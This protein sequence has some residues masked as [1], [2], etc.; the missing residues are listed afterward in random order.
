MQNS[1]FPVETSVPLHQDGVPSP[2]GHKR[3][4]TGEP[5]QQI[6]NSNHQI[7]NFIEPWSDTIYVD[8]S[9]STISNYIKE[10]QKISHFNI[11][12]RI[13]SINDEKTNNIII[14]FDARKF[15]QEHCKFIADLMSIIEDS[16]EIGQFEYDIF[17]ITINSIESYENKLI[18][19]DDSWY[20][21]KLK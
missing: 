9:N 7:I 14:E 16:G 20:L 19:A 4:R 1:G 3:R 17:N 10:E 8:T 5:P 12:K 21:N 11:E 18:D 15:N 2:R 6:H 13:K